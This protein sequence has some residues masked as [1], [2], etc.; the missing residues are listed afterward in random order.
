MSYDPNSSDS[1]F[2]RVIER[3]DTQDA[4]MDLILAEVRK[5]NGRVTS[6]EEWRFA[7]KIKV[8]VVSALVSG[9]VGFAMWAIT[10][11]ASRPT[12]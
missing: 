2:T 12:Q 5:T 7:T 9:A 4:K 10:L 8:A 6:L 3:L 1:M 11:I